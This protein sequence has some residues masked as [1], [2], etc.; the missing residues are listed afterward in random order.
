MFNNQ[1]VLIV[2]NAKQQ[3][4]PFIV[5]L[6]V[7]TRTGRSSTEALHSDPITHLYLLLFCLL[8]HTQ[9]V[10]ALLLQALQQPSQLLLSALLFRCKRSIGSSRC[11]QLLLRCSQRLPLLKH[12]SLG[13][14]LQQARW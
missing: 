6:F 10:A 9:Q 12:F 7:G 13:R 8:Q 2:C 5:F 1:S 11:T 14:F 3:L 4:P